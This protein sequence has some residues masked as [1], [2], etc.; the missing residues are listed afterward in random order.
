MFLPESA[1]EKVS[2]TAQHGPPIGPC[3]RHIWIHPYAPKDEF[4]RVCYEIWKRAQGLPEGLK[5][6]NGNSTL[7]IEKNHSMTHNTNVRSVHGKQDDISHMVEQEHMNIIIENL[8][9]SFSGMSIKEHDRQV[10]DERAEALKIERFI[11]SILAKGNSNK[12]VTVKAKKCY[13]Q[14]KSRRTHRLDEQDLCSIEYT[15]LEA[16]IAVPKQAV[17]SVGNE[18]EKRHV[19]QAGPVLMP[20]TSSVADGPTNQS[21]MS[22]LPPM[23]VFWMQNEMNYGHFQHSTRPMFYMPYLQMMNYMPYVHPYYLMRSFPKPNVDTR[24]HLRMAGDGPQFPFPNT[25]GFNPPI[26]RVAVN[27]WNLSSSGNCKKPF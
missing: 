1:P 14:D 26:S 16:R 25:C 23:P 22:T 4:D 15:K 3:P 20:P 19:K 7:K 2:E 9:E 13:I 8:S 18:T 10:L 12:N 5:P 6:K 21:H 27:N 11:K 24:D 17:V